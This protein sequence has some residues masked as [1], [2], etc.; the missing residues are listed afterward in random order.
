M[1]RSIVE[2][3]DKEAR[4]KAR[5]QLGSLKSLTIQPSTRKRYDKALT[6][7]FDYLKYNSISLPKE[8]LLMDS[9]VSEYIEHLWAS[10][11]G[12]ALASDTVA[13][14]QDTQPR[15]KGHMPTVWRLLKAWNSNEI[16]CRAPPLPIEVL[17]AMVGYAQFKGWFQFGLSLLL[18]FHGL[19]R[20]GEML[21]LQQKQVTVNSPTGKVLIS[22]GLTKGGR[23]QGASESVALHVEDI[24]RRLHFW[25]HQVPPG[26]LLVSKAHEW[27][28]TFN[29]VLDVLGFSSFGFRP[30]SLRRGGATFY[31]R[32]HSQLDRLLLQG[33]WQALRTA[34]IYINE[35]LAVL[36]ELKL[37]WSPFAKNLRSQYLSSLRQP[38]PKLELA[39][40]RPGGRGKKRKTSQKRVKA[41]S[42]RKNG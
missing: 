1:P 36:A 32:Q 31:F 22:L 39:E 29:Q 26:T 33:R 18:A 38:L 42:S 6:R 10:G 8:V 24:S 7:F 13:G 12:R 19:L 27:R 25:V 41:R 20:T 14:L 2:S 30:Y 11:E 23:R 16:P 28:K 4:A 37:S 17:E 15:L 5:Q 34:R 3:R 9:L 21:A 35:G 40:G